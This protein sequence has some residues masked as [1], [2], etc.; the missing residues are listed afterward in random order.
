MKEE[1]R[2]AGE[3]PEQAAR[4][5]AGLQD[6]LTDWLVALWLTGL[7][8]RGAPARRLPASTVIRLLPLR[9]E[10]VPVFLSPPRHHPPG[11]RPPHCLMGDSKHVAE[12][13]EVEGVQAAWCGCQFHQSSQFSQYSHQW[14]PAAP[15]FANQGQRV[16]RRLVPERLASGAAPAAPAAPPEGIWLCG[17]RL[18]RTS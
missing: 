13:P 9:F 6:W 15:V 2:L 11:T 4:R 7:Q 3:Q 8:Q 16:K 18:N 5:T 10:R 1:G 14:L 17:L 12:Q